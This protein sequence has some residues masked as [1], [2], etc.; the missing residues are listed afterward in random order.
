M[1]NP[2]LKLAIIL[3]IIYLL[4]T[5][6]MKVTKW[7]LKIAIVLLVIGAFVFGYTSVSD[8]WHHPETTNTT[9]VENQTFHNESNVTL[10]PTEDTIIEDETLK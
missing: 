1:V 3:V 7:V 10:T 8:F 2:L 9:V 6:F 5:A 4:V